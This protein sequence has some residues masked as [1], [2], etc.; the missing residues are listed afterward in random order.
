MQT[1]QEQIDDNKLMSD[2]WILHWDDI[3]LS[4]VLA[5]GGYG[6]VWKGAFPNLYTHRSLT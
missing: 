6:E 5:A 2:A 3:L 4:N 1:N